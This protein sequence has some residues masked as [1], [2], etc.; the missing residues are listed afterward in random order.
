MSMSQSLW[1]IFLIALTTMIHAK[2]FIPEDDQLVLQRLPEQ[3]FQS[4]SSTKI[5]QLRSQLKTNPEDWLSASQLA[6]YYIDLSKA[7]SDPRYMGYAQAIL[8]P[9]WQVPRP[10]TEALILR[11]IIRQN[12]HDFTNA[13]TDLDQILSVQPGHIQANLIKATIATVQGDYQIA[14]QHCQQL[15]RRASMVLS[16]ACQSGPASLSGQAETSYQLLHQVLSVATDI[17]E[18]EKIWAWTL[19]AEIAWRQGNYNSA[20]QHFKTAM[21]INASDSY[22]L[23]VYAEFLLQQHRPLEVIKLIDNETKIDSLLLRLA[24]AKKMTHSKQLAKYIDLLSER[25]RANRKRGSVLHQGDEAR[26]KLHLLNQPHAALQLAKQNW[27]LQREPAD[28]YI[29]LQSA[30]LANDME[31][32]QNIKQWL[33]KKG[34]DDELIKQILSTSQG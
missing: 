8:N 9:W 18:K 21:Q 16:L 24:L 31:A 25:F 27:Q 17:P 7:Y 15:M 14:I 28:T 30:I 19:L 34:T 3:L 33:S 13:I 6:Q 4:A 22:L 20:D 29:L 10:R 23:K 1:A 2:P 26:F 32:V 11:A 5:K 12:A